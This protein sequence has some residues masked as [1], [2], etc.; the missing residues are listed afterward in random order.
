MR[1]LSTRW[2]DLQPKHVKNKG[3]TVCY[4][5]SEPEHRPQVSSFERD[6]KGVTNSATLLPWMKGHL[7]LEDLISACSQDINKYCYKN[8]YKIKLIER[9]TY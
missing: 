3:P 5:H 1:V 9:N 6:I 7:V 2:M 8:A 4:R